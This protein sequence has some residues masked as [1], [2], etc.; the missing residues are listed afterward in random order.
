MI[1]TTDYGKSKLLIINDYTV[2]PHSTEWKLLI[3]MQQLQNK[4]SQNT[5]QKA[6]KLLP[7]FQLDALTILEVLMTNV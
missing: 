7:M 2:K 4:K 1:F 6:T 3:D 5:N